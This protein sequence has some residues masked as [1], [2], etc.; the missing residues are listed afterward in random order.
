MFKYHTTRFGDNIESNIKALRKEFPGMSF[1][2][3]M[4]KDKKGIFCLYD[5]ESREYGDTWVT[6]SGDDF[7]A[8]T[9]SNKKLII[10]KLASFKTDYED[11]I[12]VKLCAAKVTLDIF[13]ASAIPQKVMFSKRMPKV[14]TNEDNPYNT[15]DEYGKMAYELYFASRNGE[16]LKF[17]DEKFQKFV[18]MTLTRSYKLPVEVWDALEL[19]SY[20]DFDPLFAAGCGINYELLKKTL[21]ESSSQSSETSTAP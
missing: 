20:G 3:G 17:D 7:F 13:P 21:A 8:P 14:E 4:R 1:C 5:L 6:P 10:D 2:R 15:S 9:D 12:A 11:R 18:M 19:I 16:T